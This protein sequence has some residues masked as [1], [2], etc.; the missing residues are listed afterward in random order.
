MNYEASWTVPLSVYLLDPVS[1]MMRS[2]CPLSFSYPWLPPSPHSLTPSFW[3]RLQETVQALFASPLVSRR[4]VPGTLHLAVCVL[5]Q[6]PQLAHRYDDFSLS[7][8]PHW[9]LNSQ[10]LFFF[11]FFPSIPERELK[12]EFAV[13]LATTF[14]LYLTLWNENISINTFLRLGSWVAQCKISSKCKTA[15]L[16]RLAFGGAA[17][18]G[19]QSREQLLLNLW[20][21]KWKRIRNR[22]R[23]L[24]KVCTSQD[25]WRLH[26]ENSC[27]A[28][29]WDL[30]SFFCAFLWGVHQPSAIRWQ[31]R[32]RA[33][34]L[35]L[36]WLRTW[37]WR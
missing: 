10:G 30:F 8:Y 7:E 17:V 1:W 25:G 23:L 24:Q 19:S 32:W 3:L 36:M 18:R 26:G 6:R 37:G 13:A 9:L 22:W 33:V 31:R 4:S 27:K 2:V 29:K 35:W 14:N 20:A 28:G 12:G 34:R 5:R 11:F 16:A 15:H 21:E